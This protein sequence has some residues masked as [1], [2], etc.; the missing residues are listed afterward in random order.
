M[1]KDDVSRIHLSRFPEEIPVV[2]KIGQDFDITW[3]KQVEKYNTTLSVY[4]IKPKTHFSQSFGF[5][6]ELVMAISGF[7]KLEARAI[8]AIEHIFQQ[9]PAKGRVEQTVALLISDDNCAENWIHDYTSNNPQTRAYVGIAKSELLAAPD[10]WYLRN[11]FS[12]QLFSRDLF[13]YTLPLQ[14][15]L[16]F[17]G[18]QA[19]VAE[20]IDAIR[21]LENRGLFGLR[22]TGKTSLLFKIKRQ[23]GENNILVCYFDCKL[24]SIYKLSSDDFLDRICEQID[25]SVKTETG[26]W[27]T[28][29]LASDRFVALIEA[30]SSEKRLCLIFDEIEFISASSKLARHWEGQFV[31]FWQTIWSA[32]SSH[33]KFSFLV[34]GVNASVVEQ[35]RIGGIP[36]PMFGIVRATYL[37][38][39]QREEVRHLLHVFGKRMGM[40]FDEGSVDALFQRYGGH[41]LL[42]RMI[43]SQINNGLRASNSVRPV[44][45]DRTTVLRDLL[46]REEEIQFY[47]GHIT[48]ELEEFYPD[49]YFM[50][51]TLASGDVVAFNKLANE[52]DY[53]RHLRLYG[54]LD[55]SHQHSPHFKIPII[56]EYIANKWKKR[57][58]LRS[59]KYIVSPARR[60]EF[61][62]GRAGSILREMRVAEKKFISVKQPSLYAGSGACEAEL[63]ASTSVCESRDDLVAFLIQASRSFVEPIGKVGALKSHKQYLFEEIKSAYP[64]LWPALNRIRVYRNRFAHSDLT[65]QAKQEYEHYLKEDLDGHSPESVP[66]GWFQLQSAVL[67]GLLVG[68]QAEMA[69]YD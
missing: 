28:K 17:F 39:F 31:P 56:K 65:P 52:I 13:D 59:N 9:I 27:R 48:S 69:T 62:M 19:I 11:K 16:F 21:R 41:P 4:F 35:D 36:N 3:A 45:I 8:Q 7:G 22:K 58:G 37:T 5:E 38:G 29:K 30:I 14:E 15:D 40:R 1:I 46:S 49:E 54:L 26:S 24:P 64:S 18:R 50:L 61:V 6:Q 20:H 12:G 43:C 42:T 44:T 55:L 66:D 34:A 63:F 53:V 57:N 47:C 2:K 60:L 32:Q 23:S 25:Q 68:L 67:N 33:R 10:D 51:E